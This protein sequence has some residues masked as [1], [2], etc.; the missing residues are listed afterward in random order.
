MTC[1]RPPI[2][3]VGGANL[4][5]AGIPT[6]GFIPRDS[7]VG[8]VR[9]SPGGVGRNIAENLV[10]IGARVRLVTAFGDDADSMHLRTAC[11]V[12]GMDCSHCVDVAGMPCS[13]YLAV[14]DAGGDLAAA[15]NDMRALAELTPGRLDPIAFSGARAAVVDTNLPP[16]TV[17]RVAEL[18]GSV[19]LVLDPVSVVKAEAARPVLGRLA[20][21]KANLMEA[22]A[23]AGVSGAERAASA[24]LKMGVQCVF[25]T[26]GPDGVWC[27]SERESFEAPTRSVTIRNATGAG[28]AFTAGV[29]WG[30]ACG[31]SLRD[32]ADI[33]VTLSAIALESES[34]VN[35][36]LSAAMLAE[37]MEA[38]GT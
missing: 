28:D 3:V 19:P 18:A 17:A 7:N 15:V 26:M 20:A 35:E 22:E 11:E 23:L 13:R 5:V 34:T 27:A 8:H 32:T 25:V 31:L 24:L 9:T 10:R 37:R 29:A 14:L 2:T 36:R 16:A 1:E 12:L 4:D 30:M 21:L 6:G 38:S 33:A